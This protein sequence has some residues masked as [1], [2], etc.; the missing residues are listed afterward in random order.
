MRKERTTAIRLLTLIVALQ[1]FNISLNLND[2]AIGKTGFIYV[3]E[4]ETVVEFIMETCLGKKDFIPETQIPVGSLGFEE[5][6]KHISEH[7]MNFEKMYFIPDLLYKKNCTGRSMAL[8][9][10]ISDVLTPPPEA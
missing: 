5:E 3:N 8:K 10:H 1:V 4:I 9:D 7:T 6:E 2:A